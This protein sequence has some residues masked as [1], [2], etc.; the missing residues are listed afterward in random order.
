MKDSEKAAS[1]IEL[2]REQLGKFKQSRE[3]EFKVNLALWSLI[4]IAG[5]FIKAELEKV[6][7]EEHFIIY[8]IIY[9]VVSIIIVLLHCK[10]WMVPIARSQEIDDYFIRKYRF[11]VEEL[12][13]EIISANPDE[14]IKTK[15]MEWKSYDDFEKKSKKKWI[16]FETGITALLLVLVGIYILIGM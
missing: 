11:K 1:L 5:R 14:L 2:H 10:F 4:V 6:S 12:C 15:P 7:Y 9:V 13:G 8:M 16:V 3:I